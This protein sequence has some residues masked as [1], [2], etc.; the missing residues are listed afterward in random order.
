MDKHRF[1]RLIEAARAR[2]TRSYDAEAVARLVSGEAR[3]EHLPP[4]Q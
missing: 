1:W 4:W 3:P 2:A